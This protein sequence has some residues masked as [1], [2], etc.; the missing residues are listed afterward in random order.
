M[1]KYFTAA[2]VIFMDHQYVNGFVTAR[3]LF[4]STGHLFYRP[5]LH[6]YPSRG[7]MH[8]FADGKKVKNL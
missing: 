5:N 7:I 6:L 4:C 1:F 2:K 3:T 8:T